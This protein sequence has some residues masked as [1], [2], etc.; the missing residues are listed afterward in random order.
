MQRSDEKER[1]FRSGTELGRIKKKREAVPYGYREIM[2]D[3]VPPSGESGVDTEGWGNEIGEG[4]GR[5]RE[6]SQ[7]WKPL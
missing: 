5:V 6:G 4:Q 7:K 1:E 3:E 2:L